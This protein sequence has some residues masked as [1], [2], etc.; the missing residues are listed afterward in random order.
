MRFFRL[1]L[2]LLS[3][4]L[5]VVHANTKD[6]HKEEKHIEETSPIPTEDPSTPE[7]PSSK[8]MTDSYQDAF[9]RMLL[10]LVGI[11]ILVL[12]TFWI[13]KKLN[14]G[15]F[16]L[17]SSSRIH[18]LEKKSLSSKTVLYIVEIHGKEVL[19]AE[20]QLEVRNLTEIDPEI[21]S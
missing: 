18:V 19:I 17:G 12:G 5:S 1:F 4:S 14:K 2:L 21:D 3:L 6:T 10:S 8:E 9:I 13:L 7:L 16:R 20:S 15:K 11:L